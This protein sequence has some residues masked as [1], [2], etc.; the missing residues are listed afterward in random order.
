MPQRQNKGLSQ[1][2]E[3]KI[4]PQTH[5]CSFWPHNIPGHVSLMCLS[6]Q[7]RAQ[8]G[9]SCPQCGEHPNCC[10]S[11][12]QSLTTVCNCGGKERYDQRERQKEEGVLRRNPLLPR[13][14]HLPVKSLMWQA[15]ASHWLIGRRRRRIKQFLQGQM[16]SFREQCTGSVVLITG[17]SSQASS[18][19][20]DAA[21]SQLFHLICKVALRTVQML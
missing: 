4:Y 15:R 16:Q 17:R 6:A 13:S 18:L 10:G 1:E 8:G 14:Y 19:G 7:L 2:M 9:W 11:D 3:P 12:Y 20:F 21:V 5:I